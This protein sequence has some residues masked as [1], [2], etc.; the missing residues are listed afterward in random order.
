[1]GLR[2]IRCNGQSGRMSVEEETHPDG[3]TRTQKSM[4][5]ETPANDRGGRGGGGSRSVTHAFS[6]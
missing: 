6:L 2:S 1:M 3:D 5:L 4:N